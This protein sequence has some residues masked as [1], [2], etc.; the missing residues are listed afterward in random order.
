MSD[1]IEKVAVGEIAENAAGSAS[2]SSKKK[3][4]ST[5]WYMLPQSQH[6]LSPV[7]LVSSMRRQAPYVCDRD[8]LIPVR[9]H[10][11]FLFCS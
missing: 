4:V 10:H 11:N 6:R 7:A 3:K 9:V 8:W 2:P 5:D 1:I